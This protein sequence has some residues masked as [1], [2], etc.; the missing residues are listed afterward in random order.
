MEKRAIVLANGKIEDPLII[1]Q[2][3]TSWKDAI[4]IAADGGYLHA[5]TLDLVIHT[6]LGD[7]DS[8]SEEVKINFL[9]QGIHIQSFAPEKD[10][11]DLE[12]ALLHAVNLDVDRIL[13]LGAIGGRL[14]MTLSNLHLMLIP[15]LEQVQVETWYGN[16]TLWIIRPPGDEIRGQRGDTISLIPVAGT[17]KGVTTSHLKYPLKKE[18][19]S[20]GLSRGLSNVLTASDAS[21]EL[22]EGLLFVL[23]TPGHA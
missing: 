22:Q 1:R 4:V 14:D 21:I 8:M 17:A 6:I 19:L 20:I 7:L 9:D 3:L 18:N 12:L 11:T 15:Q 5:E 10:E 13:I 2:R 23:H 16:Q